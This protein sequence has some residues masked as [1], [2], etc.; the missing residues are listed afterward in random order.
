MP[1][2]LRLTRDHAFS[3]F[4]SF[5]AV[6]FQ[7]NYEIW[8]KNESFLS[9]SVYFPQNLEMLY[10]HVSV[11]LWNCVVFC[12]RYGHS[13]AN[14]GHKCSWC[15]RLELYKTINTAG[16]RPRK[17]FDFGHNCFLL[18]LKLCCIPLQNLGIKACGEC[19]QCTVVSMSCWWIMAFLHLGEVWGLGMD[20]VLVGELW[21]HCWCCLAQLNRWTISA[22]L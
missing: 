20:F 16:K 2:F 6:C 15:A 17:T 3:C 1:P 10:G 9:T 4:W 8:K 21:W 22:F 18:Q 7:A 19:Q 13:A 14:M 11:F 12:T 5:L